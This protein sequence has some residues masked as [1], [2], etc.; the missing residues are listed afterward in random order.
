MKRKEYEDAVRS[1]ERA[2]QIERGV[3]SNIDELIREAKISAKKAKIKDYYGIL[4]VDKSA[5]TDEIKKAYKKKALIH[6]PDKNPDD[7]ENAEKMFKDISEAYTILSNDKKRNMYDNGMDPNGEDHM[8]GGGVD[9]NIIFSQFFG[10]GMGGFNFGGM[11][12]GDEDGSPF[13]GFGGGF[14]PGVK[15]KFSYR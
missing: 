3:S 8:G 13:G 7:R 4:G 2:R 9:P 1:Y 15:V 10:G 6:H 11:G 5:G 14:G 12:G